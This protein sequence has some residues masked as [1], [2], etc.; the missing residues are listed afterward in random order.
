MQRKLDSLHVDKFCS[1][2]NNTEYA[3]SFFWFLRQFYTENLTWIWNILWIIYMA[4]HQLLTSLLHRKIDV[5]E[6]CRH[7]WV[8]PINDWELTC[9]TRITTDRHNWHHNQRG[10]ENLS[11]NVKLIKIADC[12][13][14]TWAVK[15]CVLL[16]WNLQFS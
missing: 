3:L 2:Y 12:R 10:A 4:N 16:A 11:F 13:N 8:H 14:L 5:S 7:S 15:Y 9:T 6:L 1:K